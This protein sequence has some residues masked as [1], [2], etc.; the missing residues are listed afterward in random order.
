MKEERNLH[1]G[2]PPNKEI[3]Q[4]GVGVGAGGGVLKALKKSTA[5]SLRRAKQTEM[6]R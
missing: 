5:A 6:H 1:P 3:S 4:D 2:R